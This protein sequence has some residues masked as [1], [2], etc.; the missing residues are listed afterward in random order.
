[1]QHQTKT[2]L[3][4]RRSV[5]FCQLCGNEDLATVCVGRYLMAEEIITLNRFKPIDLSETERLDQMALSDC[6]SYGK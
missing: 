2:Y 5:Q 1:M 3:D 4:G 6:H